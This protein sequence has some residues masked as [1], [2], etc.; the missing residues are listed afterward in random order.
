MTKPIQH[1]SLAVLTLALAACGGSTGPQG[2]PKGAFWEQLSALCGNAYEGRMT[3]TYSADRDWS[4]ERLILDVAECSSEGVVINFNRSDDRTRIWTISP[5][6][7]G[8]IG[9]H[10]RRTEGAGPDGIGT[11][12][13]ISTEGADA[14][15]QVFPIDSESKAMF[16]ELRIILSTQNVWTLTIDPEAQTLSY[17]VQRLD[18]ER[19]ME[20]DISSPVG[21]EAPE[22]WEPIDPY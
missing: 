7:D 21:V 1:V 16:E 13:G 14:M 2:L 6:P 5:Q 3:T 12:G 9:Y 4:R 10:I 17:H 20:F 8:A 22:G 19:G 18:S 11:Y 15:A